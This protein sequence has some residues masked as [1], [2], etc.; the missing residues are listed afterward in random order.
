VAT[1]VELRDIAVS[2][3]GYRY[4]VGPSRTTGVDGYFDCSGLVTYAARRLGVPNVPTVSW[5]QAQW[6]R[7]A[8]TLISIQTAFTTP[9]ALLFEGPNMGYAGYGPSGH[10]AIS[11]GNGQVIEARG[12]AYGV[13]V[14][15]AYGRPW[16]N[17][18]KVPSLSYSAP[19]PPQVIKLHPDFAAP[20]NVVSITQFEHPK[21]GKCAAMLTADGAVYCSPRNA[22]MG[23][24]NGKP[25]FKGR[26]AAA[27]R[28]VQGGYVIWSTQEERYGPTF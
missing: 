16:T 3:R 9:G 18:G 2:K 27:I 24:V 23:G 6:C 13:L 1:G 21:L 15:S 19:P 7:N 11:M 26:Q 10:V 17:A 14:D 28:P 22:Y 20:F 5:M 8:G 25:Y 4:V 12:H